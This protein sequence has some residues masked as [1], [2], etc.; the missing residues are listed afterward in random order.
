M[1]LPAITFRPCSADDLPLLA[2][3]LSRPHVARWWQ[4]DSDLAA[5]EA[6]YRPRLD[7]RDPTELLIL[8]TDGAAV[9]LFQRYLVADNQGWLTTLAHTGQPGLESAIGID[10][11]IGSPELTGRGLGTRAIAAFTALALDR[12]PA[13]THLAV[14]VSAAN[15]AS[16]RALERAG[17][18]RSWSGELPSDDPADQGPMHLYQYAR[19]ALASRP[20][21]P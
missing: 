19:A 3:W 1:S 6:K 7:G 5:V 13:A 11:L 14:A 16:W 9:G 18:R 10:Y 8:E 15:T 20:R 17:Y 2:G 21:R 12:Y 4:A